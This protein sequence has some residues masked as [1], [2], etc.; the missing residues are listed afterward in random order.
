[1]VIHLSPVLFAAL[2]AAF[3]P[4]GADFSL[5]KTAN[6]SAAPTGSGAAR[7]QHFRNQVPVADGV[8]EQYVLD[9][10]GEVEGLLLADGSHMYVTSRAADQVLHAL[11]PGHHVRVY[12]RR[13]PGELVIQ[14][15]V[16]RN[17]S[18]STTFI[19]P[20]RLDLPMPEQEHHLSV[21]ELKATGRIRVLLSHAVKGIVQGMVLSDGTQI[22]L[23]LDASEEVR[24]SFHVGDFVTVQGNGTENEFGRSIEAVAIGKGDSPLVPLDASLRSLP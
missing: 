11:K 21:T 5:T 14:P 24:R 23:P 3:N 15:D 4:A 20:L 16:I 1:M 7:D 17:L 19:V 9:P 18:T 6:S 2:I 8:I 13:K 12:G 22:R 10:R